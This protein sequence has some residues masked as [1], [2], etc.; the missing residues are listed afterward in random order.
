[1][2][3][4]GADSALLATIAADAAAAEARGK[5]SPETVDGLSAAGI[6]RSL[7]PTSLG[8]AE[9]SPAELREQVERIASTDGAAGWCAAIGATAGLAAAYL[10]EADATELLGDQGAIAAGVFAPRGRLASGPGDG[11]FELTGRWPLG[12]GVGHSTVVGLGCIDAERPERGPLYALVPRDAVEVVESWDSLGLRATA[13]HDVTVDRVAVP[14]GRVIDLVGGTPVATGPLYAFPL[15]GL[16]AVAVSAVCTGIAAGALSDVVALASERR[17]AGSSRSL[18]ER[19]TTQEGS[20]R[21]TA[22]IRAA[23]AGVEA[24]IETAWTT[25][26][27]GEPLGADE[28]A[29]LR[30]A[31]THAAETAVAVVDAAHRLGGAG[32]LYRGNPLERRFRDVHT[33]AQHMVVAAGTLELSGRVLLGLETDTAQL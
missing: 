23:R 30:I 31:S 8:G 10:P 4:L 32:S 20:A 7:V 3:T 5:L 14:A 11:A 19:A 26:E 9:A 17:P 6:F 29:G 16:L 1:M 2:A 22:S 18:A 25:A 27:R 13:S 33:A 12:S 24:A 21:A 15:F 28:R